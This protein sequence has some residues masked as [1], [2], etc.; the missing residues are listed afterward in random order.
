M[1]LLKT[2]N[3]VEPYECYHYV[4]T[5]R[6]GNITLEDRIC[7]IYDSVVVEDEYHFIFYCL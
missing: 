6:W 2:L 7:Q 3:E 4:Y 1:S 5:V